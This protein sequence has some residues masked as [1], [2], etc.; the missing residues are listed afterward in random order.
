MKWELSE[1]GTYSY[2]VYS[3]SA[4]GD[5]V[6]AMDGA[7]WRVFAA[8]PTC[9]VEIGRAPTEDDGKRLAQEWVNPRYTLTDLG[10]A[11]HRAMSGKLGGVKA[12]EGDA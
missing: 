3:S 10:A 7:D 4:L 1:D 12:G 5:I 8:L 11:Y 6:V 2:A 9:E